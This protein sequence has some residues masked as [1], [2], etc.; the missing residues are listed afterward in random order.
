MSPGFVPRRWRGAS[1]EA[2]IELCRFAEL[3]LKNY[4]DS[5]LHKFLADVA[6]TAATTPTASAFNPRC[7]VPSIAGTIPSAFRAAVL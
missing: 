1:P 4:G 2:R 7:G 5:A 3:Q 6:Y